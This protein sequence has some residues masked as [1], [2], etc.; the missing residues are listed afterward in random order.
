MPR[1]LALVAA[2]AAVPA[3]S[4]P[5]AAE[6]PLQQLAPPP[7]AASGGTGAIDPAAATRAYLDLLPASARAQ[8]DAY[9]E[10]RYWLSLW[11]VFLPAAILV[12]LLHSGASAW[13][14]DPA[15]QASRSHP[16]HA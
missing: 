6:S 8:S 5:A 2:L 13:V 14:R 7:P 3:A 9:F 1:V 11:G 4:A 10:G 16:V 12:L 15:E